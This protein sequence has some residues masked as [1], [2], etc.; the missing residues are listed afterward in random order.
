MSPRRPSSCVDLGCARGS[1]PGIGDSSMPPCRRTLLP[2][3]GITAGLAGGADSRPPRPPMFSG[4]RS[5]PY[6]GPVFVR[7]E[8]PVVLAGDLDDADGVESGLSAVG[9]AELASRWWW[10]WAWRS[11]SGFPLLGCWLD[12]FTGTPCRGY[13][14]APPRHATHRPEYRKSRGNP[15]PDTATTHPVGRSVPCPDSVGPPS[16]QP[17][18]S[19]N[20]QCVE[21]SACR[22]YEAG[23]GRMRCTQSPKSRAFLTSSAEYTFSLPCRRRSSTSAAR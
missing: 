18:R 7:V 17:A 12:L 9:H 6:G 22:A 23:S 11:W 16:S 2:T 19:C 8:E 20:R 5:V 14:P 10:W 21:P 4:R 15:L 3:P 1:A 13:R